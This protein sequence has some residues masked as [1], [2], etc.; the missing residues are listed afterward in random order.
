MKKIILL[1]S[2]TLFGW[3]GWRLGAHVGIMTAYLVSI[4]GSML[5]V[6]VGVLFNRRYL[7]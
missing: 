6:V 5:G 2:I 4:V 7:E 1:F 3:I